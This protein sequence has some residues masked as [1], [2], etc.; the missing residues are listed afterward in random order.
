METKE[1]F[2]RPFYIHAC[3]NCDWSVLEYGVMSCNCDNGYQYRK[4]C[5]HIDW[6]ADYSFE[7]ET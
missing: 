4:A 5:E 6:C 7:S 3:D 2:E 1:I